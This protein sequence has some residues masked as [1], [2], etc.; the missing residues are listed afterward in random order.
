MRE[1]W[2]EETK[3]AV[4]ALLSAERALH[5]AYL[6]ALPDLRPVFLQEKIRSWIGE[7]EKHIQLLDGAL[8]RMGDT[9][10]KKAA[11][12]PADLPTGGERHALLKYFYEA[13]ERLYY[14]YMNAAGK[15]GEG[16]LRSL[17]ESPLQDQKRHLAEIQNIY[18]ESLYY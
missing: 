4:R 15:E 5:E 18:T 14:L 11:S 3:K 12:L 2:T 10:G 8:D 9:V 6:R 7:G 16:A 13:E 17:L 1:G